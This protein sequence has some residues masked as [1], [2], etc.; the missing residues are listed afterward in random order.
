MPVQSRPGVRSL[1]AQ[2]DGLDPRRQA[3]SGVAFPDGDAL[4]FVVEVRRAAR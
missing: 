3:I 1:M 2:F 4:T